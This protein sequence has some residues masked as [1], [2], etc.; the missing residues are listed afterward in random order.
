MPVNDTPAADAAM[1]NCALCCVAGLAG[2]TAEAERGAVIADVG[3]PV[4]KIEEVFLEYAYRKCAVA[5]SDLAK[6]TLPAQVLGVQRWLMSRHGFAVNRI[7]DT[8]NPLS[9]GVIAGQM[10]ACAVGT[11]FVVLVMD[12]DDDFGATG[13]HWLTATRTAGGLSY[14]DY[15]LDVPAGQIEAMRR[16]T[17]RVAAPFGQPSI[18]ANLREAFADPSRGTNRFMALSVAP[19]TAT[20]TGCCFKCYITTATCAA[21]GLAD[22]CAEL[23]ALRRYRDEV[24]LAT[25][26]GAAAVAAYYAEAP[27]IVA[28]ID[29]LPDAAEH[30]RRLYDDFIAPA[31]AAAMAGDNDRAEALYRAGVRAA[32]ACAEIV[33]A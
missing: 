12:W 15:Q 1:V 22:D 13:A 30:Y 16:V 8:V 21:M 28:A 2:T 20:N 23:Q 24:M 9:V 18:T 17:R 4:A 27:A 29:R 33:P 31:A 3:V 5:R 14:T 26:S 6:D 25:P 7:G 32:A 11:R 19:A 10:G